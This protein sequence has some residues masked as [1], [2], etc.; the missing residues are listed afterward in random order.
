MKISVLTYNLHYHEAFE[1]IK[2]VL[3]EH[4]P[5]IACF[6]EMETEESDFS[7]LE[8]YGY[9][10]ADYT[11]SFIRGT[12]VYCIATFYRADKLQMKESESIS[13]PRSFYE[14]ILFLLRGNHDPRTVLKSEFILPNKETLSLYNVHLTPLATNNVRVKQIS[15]T[16][17][18]LK[19]HK[20]KNVI[21]AGD[22]NYPYGR[23][24]F[25]VLIQGH[26]LKEATNTINY[27]FEK[28]FLGFFSVKLKD[29][30][31]LY[32][33][34]Q[35]VETKKINVFYSDHFPILASF[36]I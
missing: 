29:D 12:K 26:N 10:L 14:V 16:L 18:D 17:Q 7:E 6:Q 5:D 15:H 3:S 22:Y 34:I 2:A 23:K 32:K 21:I 9:K 20:K 4:K 31:I 24:K 25:E 33:D 8:Q 27:T 19:L 1:G 36:Q 28:R 13:L 11:N 30:Y 35:S